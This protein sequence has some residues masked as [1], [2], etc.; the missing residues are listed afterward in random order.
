MKFQIS[1]CS[2]WKFKWSILKLP[3]SHQ[4]LKKDLSL[5]ILENQGGY[6]IQ[7]YFFDVNLNIKFR[8]ASFSVFI[9]I[10]RDA[11][12]YI[13]EQNFTIF[14]EKFVSKWDKQEVYFNVNSLNCS[15]KKIECIIYL[16]YIFIIDII[17][18][19]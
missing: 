16:S 7:T 15:W 4:L 14:I 19:H 10:H 5:S 9:E 1:S 3:S 18:Y 17:C 2:K 11:E 12:K 8:L 13:D 6:K